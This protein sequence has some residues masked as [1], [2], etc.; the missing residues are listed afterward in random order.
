MLAHEVKNSLISEGSVYETTR[1]LRN[2]QHFSETTIH[3]RYAAILS[4]FN[5][6][7][8]EVAYNQPFDL[9]QYIRD[10]TPV[11]LTT[12]EVLDDVDFI[13]EALDV[14]LEKGGGYVSIYLKGLSNDASTP[15]E[16]YRFDV[17]K[18]GEYYLSEVMYFEMKIL[19]G[20]P[21]SPS[22]VRIWN[23]VGENAMIHDRPRRPRFE[24]LRGRCK[25]QLT[26]IKVYVDTKGRTDE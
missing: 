19:Y 13:V 6:I 5:S 1:R 24:R 16:H 3:Q 14:I 8:V 2:H 20:D 12:I 21:F 18:N 26:P 23:C 7:D 25:T 10:Q 22:G 17:L 15:F 4:I 11:H 9:I